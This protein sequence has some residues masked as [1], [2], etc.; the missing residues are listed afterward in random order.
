MLNQKN[1]EELSEQIKEY[2]DLYKYFPIKPEKSYSYNFFASYYKAVID[3]FR[4]GYG[5]HSASVSYYVL[6]SLVP[7]LIV[8]TVGASYIAHIKEEAIIKIIGALFPEVTQEFILFTVKLLS[9]QRTFFGIFGFLLAFYFSTR[10]FTA[11]HTALNHTFNK[12]S[13]FK[14]TALVYILGVPIFKFIV[15]FIYIVS[16]VISSTLSILT[17]SLIWE[18]LKNFFYKI[19][20]G[21][22]FVLITNITNIVIFISFFII[23]FVIYHFLAPREE[24]FLK[25]T[26]LVSILSS[27]LL[28]TTKELFNQFIALA[29]KTNPLYGSLS[30]IFT[31]LLWLY[32][33]FS[34]V[35]IGSRTIYNLEKEYHIEVGES[36]D[37]D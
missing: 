19:G 9:E 14:R 21:D 6:M 11:L 33:G 15:I 17:N 1:K 30:G 26:I 31:F 12:D 23:L 7:L 5:Y 8:I 13:G 32:I 27:F 36:H 28:F 29:A 20:I 34:I 25:D 22:I 10:L 2:I 18:T 4:R 3:Y 37:E 35:I 24:K 16:I